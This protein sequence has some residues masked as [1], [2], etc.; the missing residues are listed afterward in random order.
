MML[1]P[2]KKKITQ[3][4]VNHNKRQ[5]KCPTQTTSDSTKILST[6]AAHVQKKGNFNI[7]SLIPRPYEVYVIRTCTSKQHG[8]SNVGPPKDSYL[9]R[10]LTS[11]INYDYRNNHEYGSSRN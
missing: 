4:K 9:L 8:P 10:L 1:H 6:P 2:K 3:C 5:F 11:L 7:D